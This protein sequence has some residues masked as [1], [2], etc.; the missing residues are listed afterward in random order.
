MFRT[1][2]EIAA[3]IAAPDTLQGLDHADTHRRV[4]H[5]AAKGLLEGG[6]AVD[7]RGTQVFPALETYRARIFD[8]LGD[9]GIAAETLRQ[10]SIAAIRH[11][12][13]MSA[14]SYGSAG[15]LSRGALHDAIRGVAAGEQWNL[16]IATLPPLAAHM[17]G[18]VDGYREGK[19]LHIAFEWAGD[20][21]DHTGF[22][23]K[24][25]PYGVLKLDLTHLFKPI[26]ERIGVPA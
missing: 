12:S 5:W 22:L 19:L 1:A 24:S 13:R 14:P 15:N 8:A 7:R 2:S 4:R 18:M 16:V 20:P 6:K 10:V 23:D 3:I 25:K 17:R 26:V 11:P 21:I 9:F